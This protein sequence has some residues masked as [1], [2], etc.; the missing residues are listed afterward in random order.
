LNAFSPTDLSADQELFVRKS[1][2]SLK[3]RASQLAFQANEKE[4]SD[5]ALSGGCG[6]K[7]D[8][9]LRHNVEDDLGSVA[10]GIIGVND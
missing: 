5:G 9:S 2:S 8:F 3:T 1:L 6:G 4:K 7:S 10:P